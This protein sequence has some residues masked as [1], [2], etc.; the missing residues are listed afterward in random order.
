MY[1]SVRKTVLGLQLLIRGLKY[2]VSPLLSP[3]CVFHVEFPC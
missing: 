2:F 1:H 3:L